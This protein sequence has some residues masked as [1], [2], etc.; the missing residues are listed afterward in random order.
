MLDLAY[1][2]V[3]YICSSNDEV[4][5]G[6]TGL[7]IMLCSNEI[8]DV[9]RVGYLPVIDAFPTILAQSKEIADKLELKYA[10]LVFDEGLKVNS[11]FFVISFL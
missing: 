3:M 8:P 4:L 6:W 9:S 5:P 10:A 11:K 2:L 1:I 7:N